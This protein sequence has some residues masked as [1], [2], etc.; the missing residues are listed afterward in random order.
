MFV[1]VNSHVLIDAQSII[2]FKLRSKFRSRPSSRCSIIAKCY[3]E[4]GIS[5]H[6]LTKSCSSPEDENLNAFNFLHFYNENYL[7]KEF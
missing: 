4:N 7:I 6:L 1:I 5:T 3:K 2:Y